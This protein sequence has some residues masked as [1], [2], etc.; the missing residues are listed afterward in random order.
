MSSSTP[1]SPPAAACLTPP[2]AGGI[3]VVEVVG[4]EAATVVNPLLAAKRPI[5][6]AAMNADELR[7]C[8]ITDRGEVLDDVIVAARRLANGALV[9][10]LSVH[11]GTRVVQRVLLA[12]AAAGARIIEPHALARL[13]QPAANLLE[14]ESIEL[15]TRVKTRPV[16]A[17]LAGAPAAIIREAELIDSLLA[18]GRI[19][20]G[21]VALKELTARFAETRY[22]L[23]GIRVVL[24]GAPNSGKSTLANA[25]A[26]AEH[27]IVSPTA[28]TTR[29]WVE[30]PAAIDGVPVTLVDTAGIAHTQDAIEQEAI[31]RAEEQLAT[32]DIILRVVDRSATQANVLPQTKSRLSPEVLVW[33]KCD[34][35]LAHDTVSFEEQGGIHVSALTADGLDQLRARIMAISGMRDWSQRLARPYTMRQYR[36]CQAA[37]A[38][39]EAEC[40]PTNLTHNLRQ[41]LSEE[42]TFARQDSS[43]MV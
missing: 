14:A 27:S 43:G 17:W 16:A 15:L 30:L 13:S 26:G 18:A 42:N 35:P 1:N 36:A 5:D 28:G 33:N 39:L 19:E 6:V 7:L 8:R 32:A 31:R 25:L 3:A 20:T 37:L 24:T 9:V 41:L 29:D 12:L 21:R 10:D 22:L 11:G 23:D 4:A 38:K 40:P 2:T 34:L